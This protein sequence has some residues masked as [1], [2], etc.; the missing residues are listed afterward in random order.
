MALRLRTEQQLV[1]VEREV[2]V[3]DVVDVLDGVDSLGRD[4]V[5]ARTP[6]AEQTV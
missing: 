4:D 6:R 5:V 2:D 3:V 1:A